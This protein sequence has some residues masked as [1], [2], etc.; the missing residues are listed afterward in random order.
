MNNEHDPIIERMRQADTRLMSARESIDPAAMATRVNQRR[1]AGKRHRM[2]AGLGVATVGFIALAI[3][4]G[5]LT[6]QSD[7][8]HR[9]AEIAKAANASHPSA[10]YSNEYHARSVALQN[11]ID[12]LNVLE[13]ENDRLR[14]LLDERQ[15]L[16]ERIQQVTQMGRRLREYQLDV[17]RAELSQSVFDNS[18]NPIVFGF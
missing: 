3:T 12:E 16:D 5:M 10:D 6:R 11:R 1:L 9:T 14:Q 15:A 2:I 8:E 13:K 7:P 18:S 17:I 4:A